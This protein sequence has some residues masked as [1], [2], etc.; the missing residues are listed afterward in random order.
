MSRSS[1]VLCTLSV[2]TMAWT[3]H[4][5][6]DLKI[7]FD[8]KGLASII[9]NEVDLLKPEDPR[10]RLHQV[11]YIDAQ[12]K[13]GARQLY[14][15][16]VASQRFD[17]EKKI[18]VQTYPGFRV[19]CAFLPGTNRL[20]MQITLVNTG[21]QAICQCEFLP[22]TIRLPHT[23]KN[24]YE[25]GRRSAFLV[26]AY[27]HAGGTVVVMPAGFFDYPRKSEGLQDLRPLY[28]VG[29]TPEN[30]PHH[31]VVDDA[32]WY[33]PGSAVPPGK[34]GT[35]RV[36]LVFGPAGTTW[37]ELCPEAYD[38]YA[39]ANPMKLKW[40]DRRPIATSFL[41]N[42]ATG[43]KTN[44][45]GYFQDSRV[46][47][48]TEEGVKAFGERLMKYAD[49]CIAHMKQ[50]DSQGIIVWDIEGQEMP[51]M[52]SYIGDPRQL[53]K[54]SPEMDRFA[55]AFMQKF[56]DAG[57]RTGITIRPT[58]AYQPNVTNQL[59]WNQRETQDPVATLSAK[60]KYAQKRW[61][62]TIFYLDSSVFGDG[63]L[64]EAQKKEM[65]N[66]PWVMPVSMLEKLTKLHPDCLISPEFARRDLYR[67]GAPYSSPN[68]GEGGTDPLI[69]R[70]WPQ[71]FR[72]IMSRQ[73]LMEKRWEQY[74]DS[75]EK[76]DVLMF[77]CWGDFV[78]QTFVKLLYR[79][80]VMRKGGA[81]TAL[82]T[83]DVSTLAEKVRDSSEET[84]YAAA[85]ALGKTGSPAAVAALAGLLKDERPLVRKQALAGLA[86][87]EKIDDPA[88]LALLGEWIKGSKDPV[89][90]ALRS[91]AAEALAKGGEAVVPEL[92]GLLADEKSSGVWLYAVRALGRTATTNA[93][94]A[95]IL[96]AFLEDKAPAKVRLRND[97]IESLGLLKVK[98][99]VALLLPILDKQ[100][101]NSEDERGAVVVAL[102]RI[103]DARAVQPLLNQFKV[104]YST[105]VVYWIQ[106]ALDTALRSITSEKNVIGKDEW[107]RW[108]AGGKG[109]Q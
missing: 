8:E 45:R 6:E 65:H 48:T 74:A 4:A 3:L 22:L 101:R 90:N 12:A 75:V 105:V 72:L 29:P 59:P 85:T 55:D 36:S 38:A 82:A 11:Y 10:F 52:V 33:D 27:E 106:G 62:C 70:L 88:C 40:P 66:I 92:I 25:W 91:Q 24:A 79:E 89:Q 50:M 99:A 43:W 2:L 84:R 13:G 56:R 30:R 95:Q 34:T 108:N 100:D 58:E 17:M 87:A 7:G 86:R 31:P 20:D 54:L 46:D 80:A 61:G 15:P 73:D 68:L 67:F 83:A 97:V 32:Y 96:M 1:A 41:C 21:T 93:S 102:G 64:T 19:E 28:L 76:G 109:K 5:A 104:T 78:E 37:Q 49:T 107:L 77:C 57:F 63:L 60:I 47:V 26:D 71:A 53:A 42:A 18:L 94:A 23:V 16:Q 98:E 35:Y 51:H 103:G 39:K 81:L 14:G 69:R 9:H 44:P